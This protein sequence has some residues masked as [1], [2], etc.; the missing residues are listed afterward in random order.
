KSVMPMEPKGTRPISTFRPESRS[1][2]SEPTPMPMENVASRIVT[3]VSSPRSTSRAN[4]VNEVRK[5]EP[6]NQSHEI[7]SSELKTAL[8]GYA[9]FRFRGGSENGF[10]LMRRSGATDG[11]E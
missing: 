1:Q 8:L 6:K 5:T 10:R 4:G 2:A 9:S 3:I 11:V 7:P